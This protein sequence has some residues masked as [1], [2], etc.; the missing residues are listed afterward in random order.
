MLG[1]IVGLGTVAGC[2][3]G[4]ALYLGKVLKMLNNRKKKNRF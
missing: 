2:G 3:Y 1:T 4:C